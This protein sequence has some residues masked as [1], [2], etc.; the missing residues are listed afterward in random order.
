MALSVWPCNESRLA[1]ERANVVHAQRLIA[2]IDFGRIRKERLVASG[3]RTSPPHRDAQAPLAARGWHRRAHA[4]AWHARC[5]RSERRERLQLWVS[6]AKPAAAHR[7]GS[8]RVHA[9][10]KPR[11]L[12]PGIIRD[13][14]LHERLVAA[15][16]C[17][18]TVQSGGTQRI[19]LV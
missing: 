2:R 7:K 18:G 4:S 16:D 6:E 19:K 17:T 1:A 9:G 11:R 12:A 15:H 8:A 10:S 3:V 5:T 13:E 14:R